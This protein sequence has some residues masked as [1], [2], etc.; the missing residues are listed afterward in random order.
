MHGILLIA[1][2][3]SHPSASKIGSISNVPDTMHN[4]AKLL[5]MCNSLNQ[6]IPALKH[7]Y[8]LIYLFGLLPLLTDIR[9]RV[10]GNR[11]REKGRDMQQRSSGT[12][13]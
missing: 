12:G 9:E 11:D 5:V 3:L 2:A 13:L 8:Y 4:I 1:T 6:D 7:G 10:T